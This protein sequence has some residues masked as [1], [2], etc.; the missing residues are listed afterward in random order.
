MRRADEEEAA[1]GQVRA[2]SAVHAEAEDAEQEDAG[3]DADGT[4]EDGGPNLRRA[5][6]P[7]EPLESGLALRR[8]ASG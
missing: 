2:A 5:T 6:Q 4:V 8:E 3:E 7:L 1:G